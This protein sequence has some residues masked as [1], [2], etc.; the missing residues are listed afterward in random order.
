M[1]GKE[2]EVTSAWRAP[3]APPRN[4]QVSHILK[5]SIALEASLKKYI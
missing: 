2:R 3:D 4:N 5:G 1:V